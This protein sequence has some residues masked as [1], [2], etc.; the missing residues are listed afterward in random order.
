MLLAH[1]EAVKIYRA[2]FATAQGGQIGIVVNADWREPRKKDC[3]RHIMAAKTAME[4]SLGWFA[5]P[6][7]FGDYPD[8][9]RQACGSRLPEFTQEEKA[10]VAGSSDF[11]GINS[12]SANF[13]SPLSREAGGEGYWKDIGVAWWH[14]DPWWE[15]TDMGW[16]V[17]PWGFRELLL[18]IHRTYHPKGGIIVTENGCAWETE[19]SVELDQQKAALRPKKAAKSRCKSEAKLRKKMEADLQETFDDPNRV[20]FLK[21]HLCAVH[22]ARAGGAD[23]RGYFAWSLLDNFEWAYGYTKRFGIVRVDYATQKRTI[24]SSG[25]FVSSVIA[26]RG[27]E[28]PGAEEQFA[29]KVF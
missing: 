21:S 7:F 23:V 3:E 22:A 5:H 2:D 17:V 1:A 19:K 28:A 10:S 27:F 24:K 14:S 9:M 18:Y 6:V 26:Q 15:K 25:R 29:G 4:F 8:C 12:Y 20:R 16:N 11:F 13:A